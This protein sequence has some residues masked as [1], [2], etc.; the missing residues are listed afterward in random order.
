M[1]RQPAGELATGSQGLVAIL[2]PALAFLGEQPLAIEAIAAARDD[3]PGDAIAQAQR[4]TGRVP[5]RR[6]RAEG[7]DPAEDLMA[8]DRRHRLLTPPLHRVDVAAAER[9]GDD[10]HQDLGTL[11]IGRGEIPELERQPGA[12]EDQR[13]RG[14]AHEA[15]PEDAAGLTRVE[16]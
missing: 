4:L 3:R 9:A 10:L 16:K 13:T 6:G 11:G 2:D 7:R 12:M 8:E 15:S 5:L 14:S 1:L